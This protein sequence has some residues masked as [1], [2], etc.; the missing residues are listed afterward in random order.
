MFHK[1]TI[2]NKSNNTP[3]KWCWCGKYIESILYFLWKVQVLKLQRDD[4]PSQTC[5]CK[6][7]LNFSIKKIRKLKGGFVFERRCDPGCTTCQTF[8]STTSTINNLF[9]I[10]AVKMLVKHHNFCWCCLNLMPSFQVSILCAYV[11][12]VWAQFCGYFESC[13]TCRKLLHFGRTSFKMASQRLIWDRS[14]KF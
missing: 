3:S 9:C 11:K 5:W 4:V 1:K 7:L 12:S 14:C 8:A 13:G 2:E 6:N 10:Y